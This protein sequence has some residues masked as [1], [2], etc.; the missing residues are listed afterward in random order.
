MN[1]G[2]GASKVVAPTQD[3]KH[4]KPPK[5]SKMW[6]CNYRWTK[7]IRQRKNLAEQLDVSQQAVFNRLR[8]MGKIHKTG[9][10]WVPRAQRGTGAK[11]H[12]TFCSVGTK[13][14]RFCIE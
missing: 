7:M 13:E 1:D 12:V 11:T 2:F 9:T 3:K 4:G 5:N 10:Q 6:N 14:S 8:E